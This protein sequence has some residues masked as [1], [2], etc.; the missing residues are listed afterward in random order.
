[1]LSGQNL[2]CFRQLQSCYLRQVKFLYLRAEDCVK[3]CNKARI[4]RKKMQAGRISLY[5]EGRL[6][7]EQA[8]APCC[9]EPE[10]NRQQNAARQGCSSVRR[11]ES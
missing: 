2:P 3:N 1:M 11:T 9:G 4:G 10:Q 5:Q 6:T 7:T 8:P